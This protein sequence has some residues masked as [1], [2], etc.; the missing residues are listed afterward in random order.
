MINKSNIIDL[1]SYIR[2]SSIKESFEDKCLYVTNEDE[3]TSVFKYSNVIFENSHLKIRFFESLKLKDVNHTIIN[4]L[5][6]IQ[7]FEDSL[8]NANGLVVF[9]NVCC[10]KNNEILE[11]VISCK[12]KKMLIC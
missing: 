6:S 7:I 10:C 9:D 5:S 11:K 8:Y 4:C 1:N 3:L 2:I 12:K